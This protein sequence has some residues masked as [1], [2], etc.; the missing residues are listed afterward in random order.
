MRFVTLHLVLA[1]ELMSR[2]ADVVDVLRI[3]VLLNECHQGLSRRHFDLLR[4][5]ILQSYGH[6]HILTL[7]ALERAGEMGKHCLFMSI[8]AP[9][10]CCKILFLVAAGFLRVNAVAGKN[11]FREVKN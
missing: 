3:V 4:H 1:Q 6:E 11:T 5:E 2:G 9:V 7:S 8:M 10:E